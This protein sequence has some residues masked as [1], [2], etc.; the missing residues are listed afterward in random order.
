MLDVDAANA[1][2]LS[3]FPATYDGRY[4]LKL[5]PRPDASVV[6]DNR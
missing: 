6:F 4:E 5:Y 3:N 1:A 2:A